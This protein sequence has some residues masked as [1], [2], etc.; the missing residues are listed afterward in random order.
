[1]LHRP[2]LSQHKHKKHKNI[3]THKVANSLHTCRRFDTIPACNGRTDGRNCRSSY[4][5]CNAARCKNC[6]LYQRP[7]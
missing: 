3:K 6:V 4:S 2:K 1:M 7:L 5:A